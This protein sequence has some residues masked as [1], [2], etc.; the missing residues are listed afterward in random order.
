MF[1]MNPDG[2]YTPNNIQM[3]YYKDLIFSNVSAEFAYSNEQKTVYVKTDFSW[4]KGNNFVNF[5]NH[6]KLTCRFTSTTSSTSIVVPAIMETTIIGAY[7]TNQLPEQIR[8]RIPKWNSADV[9][10]ME[11]SVNGQDY[12]GNY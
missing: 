3:W 2:D 12:M 1:I 9:I 11:V 10:K 8:C 6:A 5:R 4:N 7:N